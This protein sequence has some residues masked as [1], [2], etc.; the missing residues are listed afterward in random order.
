MHI[1]YER[2]QFNPFHFDLI[3]FFFQ[4]FSFLVGGSC[5]LSAEEDVDLFL[6]PLLRVRS[7]GACAFLIHKTRQISQL[8]DKVKE[9]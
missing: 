5:S 8:V 4:F 7:V 9:L 3:F 2:M 6:D 1:I